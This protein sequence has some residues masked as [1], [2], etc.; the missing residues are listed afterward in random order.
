[1][2]TACGNRPSLAGALMLDSGTAKSKAF[3]T[4]GDALIPLSIGDLDHDLDGSLF[5]VPSSVWIDKSSLVFVGSEAIR[6]GELKATD[7]RRQR[8]DSLKQLVSQA[9]SIE[10][11]T[12]NTLS[13]AENPTARAV[14]PDDVITLYLGYLTD[15]ATS[16]LE[17]EG[18]PRY[19][20]RRFSLPCWSLSHR[21]WS[22]PYLARLIGRAQL[23]ADTFHGRWQD[24]IAVYEFLAV[25]ASARS[26][27]EDA[28][29]WVASDEGRPPDQ[30]RVGAA[31]SNRWQP[32]RR[33]YGVRSDG[34]S[35]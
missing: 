10:L 4:H 26:H 16:A 13:K 30:C 3:A 12:H 31:S 33:A 8:L 17:K 21:Q 32:V 24:G 29:R 23:V 25:V 5:A 27:D 28:L 1:M 14:T 19:V 2:Q 6:R 34:N 9:S 20:K 7:G 35:L 22:A 11:L 18:R 15:L